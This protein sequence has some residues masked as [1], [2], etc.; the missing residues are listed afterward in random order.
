MFCEGAAYR[1]PPKAGVSPMDRD[2]D[3]D[4]AMSALARNRDARLDG[5]VEEFVADPEF[6]AALRRRGRARA[7]NDNNEAARSAR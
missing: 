1:V 5:Y 6:R 4:R 2:S 7:E 3:V